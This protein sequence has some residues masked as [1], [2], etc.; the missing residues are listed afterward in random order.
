MT[1]VIHPKDPMFLK[2][3]NGL[4][5]Q[6]QNMDAELI[7]IAVKCINAQ[8]HDMNEFTNM[9]KRDHKATV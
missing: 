1:D 2:I 6:N 8:W 3:A 7:D 4:F 5:T 9:F